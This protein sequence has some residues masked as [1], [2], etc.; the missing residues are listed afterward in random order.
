[1][2]SSIA[3][4]PVEGE[5]HDV[6]LEAAGLE[7]VAQGIDQHLGAAVGER[8]LGGADDDARLH[9]PSSP[10]RFFSSSRR[11]SA[12]EPR[13]ELAQLA[14]GPVA[15]LHE[16][17][18]QPRR[19]LVVAVLL[20]EEGPHVP[21]E[22]QF[23][24]GL[25]REDDQPAP[26]GRWEKATGSCDVLPCFQ[27]EQAAARLLAPAGERGRLGAA[28]AHAGAD[29]LED[30]GD[31]EV[32]RWGRRGGVGHLILD[33]RFWILDWLHLSGDYRATMPTAPLLSGPGILR[34]CAGPGSRDRLA[35]ARRRPWSPG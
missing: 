24:E 4:R 33:F 2:S 29:L 31:A 13:R 1:M 22:E 34:D 3:R 8:H 30:L 27:G 15:R 6:H 16:V 7:L 19:R 5:G 26:A 12:L 10:G 20:L 21:L 18:D 17:L 25:A 9:A 28:L 35:R 11:S 23:V 32:F 14:R